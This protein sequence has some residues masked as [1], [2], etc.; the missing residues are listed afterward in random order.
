M[1]HI[2]V[3]GVWYRL[4]NGRMLL[5]DV[6]F[7]V[8]DGQK[9]AFVGANGTGKS[10]LARIIACETPV[11]QGSVIRD[12]SLGIMPQW[13]GMTT[14]ARTV[15]QMVNALLPDDLRPL[16]EV[17]HDADVR[18]QHD[19]S[20]AAQLAFVD[21]ITAW[22]DAGG[23]DQDVCWEQACTTALGCSFEDIARRRASSLS[24][25]EQKRLA[26]EILLESAFDILLL[27]EPDNA[28]DI[29]GKEWLEQR[30]RETRKTILCISHDRTVIAL[31]A[32]RI[33]TFEPSP[34][35]TTTWLFG[36]DFAAWQEERIARHERYGEH[37]KRWHEEHAHL[38]D[39]VR[40]IGDMARH[41]E[42]MAPRYKAVQN[43]LKRFEEDGPPEAP[44]L[45]QRV[46]MRLHGGRTGDRVL[47]VV[48]VA[49]TGILPVTSLSLSYGERVAIVGDNGSGKSHVLRAIA[50]PS[51]L[52]Q[53]TVRLGARVVPG[54]FAQ[55]HDQTH[56]HGKTPLM[57]LWAAASLPVVDAMAALRRYELTEVA[58]VLFEDLSGGQQARLQ[59]LLLELGGATLLLLDEP[60]D[61]LD[62]ESAEALERGLA[63]YQ[64]TVLAVTHDRWFVQQ[65]D[66][67]VVV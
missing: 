59:I 35:G 60:T 32:D 16:A 6:S 54:V 10:T 33:V 27:D 25:G 28:L 43:R 20:D 31:V 17:L 14:G 36:G 37:L 7:R 56:F 18:A 24:G 13:I 61:N 26:L 8:G 41:N 12:G 44:P 11:S 15:W 49:I 66:R 29:A 50:D 51:M 63:R 67:V 21:A 65:F 9:V 2:D 5:R 52:S 64:G 1:P 4:P 19:S 58:A 48:D 62:L 23:Y 53:G 38:K 42:Q 3:N 46:D 22:G 47:E 40:H 39:M 30:L 34:R 57:I 55:N 45:V